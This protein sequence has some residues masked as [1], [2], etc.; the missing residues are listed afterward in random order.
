M[1]TWNWKFQ[2]A[3]DSS[4][5]KS[6]NEP[7]EFTHAHWPQ[8]QIPRVF[9]ARTSR[10]LLAP[11]QVAVRLPLSVLRYAEDRFQFPATMKPKN[12]FSPGRQ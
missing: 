1:L 8:I 10:S 12:P 5:F 4:L 2:A 7:E 6:E 3:L 11:P 9:R